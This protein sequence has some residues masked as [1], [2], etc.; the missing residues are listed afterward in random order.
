LHVSGE[1]DAILL[2]RARTPLLVFPVKFP[3]QGLGSCGHL[4][5]DP[6]MPLAILEF[7]ID[8]QTVKAFLGRDGK[9]FAREGG[10]FFAGKSEFEDDPFYFILRCLDSL[11]DLD[12]LSPG[13]QRERTHLLQ[14]DAQWIV[15]QTAS[16]S[17]VCGLN[18]S[19]FLPLRIGHL[20]EAAVLS[21]AITERPAGPWN[22]G[23]W[24]RRSLPTGIDLEKFSG[25]CGAMSEGA[26][27][28]SH[29]FFHLRIRTTAGP[30]LA[31]PS[32]QPLF[33][34][35]RFGEITPAGTAA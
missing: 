21:A 6:E 30:Q 17:R 9:E 5:Q 2:I 20:R 11:A 4:V 3:I 24:Q 27:W 8:N 34:S 15:S 26:D 29:T 13:Q 12:L 7:G 16:A 32:A 22:F 28:G 23:R 25:P 35:S 14:I 31:N 33:F 10:V 1:R 19:C 18:V